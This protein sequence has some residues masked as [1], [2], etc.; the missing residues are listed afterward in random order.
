MADG[1]TGGGTGFLPS[2]SGVQSVTSGEG[3]VVIGGTGANPTVTV[4]H[5]YMIGSWRVSNKTANT[6][7]SLLTN[8]DLSWVPTKAI[9][10]RRFSYYGSGVVPG[11]S[12]AMLVEYSVNGGSSW[13]TLVSITDASAVAFQDAVPSAPIAVAAGAEIRIRA[14]TDASWTG[15]AHDPQVWLEVEEQ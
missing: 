6:I 2:S 15:T 10:L 5:R 11:G 13:A 4:K 3:T 8:G 9:N 7:Q 1:F 12:S 14:T